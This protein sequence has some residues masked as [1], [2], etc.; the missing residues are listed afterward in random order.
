MSLAPGGRLRVHVLLRGQRL[1]PPLAI[2]RDTRRC[3]R[4]SHQD[5]QALPLQNGRML[6]AGSAAD[7]FK[8]T[9]MTY[10]LAFSWF[11]GSHP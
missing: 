5:L 10:L 4:P 1:P 3:H 9:C 8:S 2:A 11:D 7:V 6:I